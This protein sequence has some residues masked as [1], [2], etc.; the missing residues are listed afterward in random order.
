M[1]K[2]KSIKT[3]YP[4]AKG[5]NCLCNRATTAKISKSLDIY[6]AAIDTHWVDIVFIS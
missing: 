3:I 1:Q 6:G 4:C 5:C 2:I